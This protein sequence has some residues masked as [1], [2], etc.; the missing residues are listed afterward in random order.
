MV[1]SRNPAERIMRI[2]NSHRDVF[3]DRPLVALSELLHTSSAVDLSMY[4]KKWMFVVDEA[5]RISGRPPEVQ[6]E[7]EVLFTIGRRTLISKDV[8]VCPH[9]TD[10]VER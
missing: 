1:F 5:V 7:I 10:T 6:T 2:S 8:R 9:S 4:F 3:V